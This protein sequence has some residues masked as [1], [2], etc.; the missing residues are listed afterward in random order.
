MMC[1]KKLILLTIPLCL[2]SQEMSDTLYSQS[3]LSGDIK[4]INTWW[5]GW[6]GN[7]ETWDTLS[8]DPGDGYTHSMGAHAVKSFLSFDISTLYID[9]LD[10]VIQSAELNL[11]QYYCSGEGVSWVYPVWNF[12]GGD[13]NYCYI[14]HVDY[15]DSLDT[16]DWT[17]GD[18]GDPQT[19]TPLAGL[20]SSTADIGWR[21]VDITS[22][23]TADMNQNRTRS[24]FRIHFPVGIDFD[25]WGDLLKFRANDE[26]YPDQRPHIIV[27]Y[28][29][30]PLNV[31]TD[32]P[33]MPDRYILHP[34]YPN[35]FNPATRILYDVPQES[36]IRLM[37][38]DLLGREVT[39][40]VNK[41]EQ[42]GY[43]AIMWNGRDHSGHSLSSGLYIYR[44]E[45][46]SFSSSQKMLLL[47]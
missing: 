14:D 18:E 11:Y 17:A 5:S 47:K 2:Y 7:V 1:Y 38:Y 22:L 16:L 40:L 29:T 6:I 39:T 13:T 4:Y 9:S 19:L 43:K 36:H 35:P 28:K 44:L 33:V 30:K 23:L 8:F 21:S 12:P 25:M 10:V 24:Q 37:V 34:N 45:T 20:A 42:P 26:E 3:G 41:I 15:G 32:S 31:H 46:E 27:S